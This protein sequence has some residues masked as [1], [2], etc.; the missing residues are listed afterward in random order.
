MARNFGGRRTGARSRTS[1]S[2]RRPLAALSACRAAAIAAPPA[3]RN[4][5][6]SRGRPGATVAR[7][8][9][10]SPVTTP[11]RVAPSWVNVASFMRRPP[12][13]AQHVEGRRPRRERRPRGEALDRLPGLVP[14]DQLLG[15]E[16]HTDRVRGEL[17]GP[18]PALDRLGRGQVVHLQLDA[19]A[20]GIL[21]VERCGRS[22]VDA[23]ERLDAGGLQ[24]PERVEQIAEVAV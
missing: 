5:T 16:D 4:A 1:T 17:P 2:A 22:V 7:S 10:C 11:I 14:G 18:H 8:T 19:A 6:M 20:V 23:P 13:E 21:V 24:A 15:I 3:A 9:T 12:S